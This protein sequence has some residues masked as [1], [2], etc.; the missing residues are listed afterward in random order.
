MSKREIIDFFDGFA[1]RWDADLVRD[2]EV[3]KTILDNA[4]I[5]AGASVLDVACGTGVLVPDYLERAVASV[6]CVD[7]SPRMIAHARRK[8]SHLHKVHFICEDVESAHFTSPFDCIVVYNS[9]PHFF[10]A[11]SLI[12][13]L[14]GDLKTGGR[15]TIA[16]GMSREKINSH[17]SGSASKVSIKL[18]HEDELEKRFETFVS[19]TA[20][21]SND[22]MY[23]LVGVKR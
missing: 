9:F 3:I 16:H 6:T 8:F 15:L 17:H 10:Q 18:M 5:K 7:I 14:A 11:T 4:D 13:K 20:K 19:V 12:E 1:P 23:Q 2:E 21:I 22:R